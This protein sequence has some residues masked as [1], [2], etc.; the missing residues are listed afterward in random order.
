MITTHRLSALFV[1]L[2]LAPSAHAQDEP[3]APIPLASASRLGKAE[4]A[5]WNDPA[6][7]R[8]FAESYLAETDIEPRV[9]EEERQRMQEILELI[10]ADKMDEAAREIEKELTRNAAASAVFDFT[11]A[12]IY[13]Q[14]EELD[15]AVPGYE[16]AVQKF[17][18][19]RR[20]WKN[21]GLIHI[22]QGNHAKA[23]PALTRVLELGGAD[24]LTYGLLGFACSSTENPIAAESA[25]RMAI[26]LGPVTLDWKMGLARSFFRQER[27][28]EASALCKKLIESNPDQTDLWLLQANAH[29]GLGRPLEA[30]QLYE[31]VDQMGKST[32]DSLNMLGDIHINQELCDVA[33]E[34]R[35]H[36]PA[37]CAAAGDG[38]TAVA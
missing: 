26:M 35:V 4:L 28:A 34:S 2:A 1:L 6:F 32:A 13:F 18:K 15:R 37:S 5:I 10:A 21:L 8:Q 36:R 12:N 30:A 14:R 19:F 38:G 27:F 22:R 24:A 31:L 17:P 29:I 33:A 25:Y 16:A 23:L 20:A 3:A 7:K 11:L 9:T